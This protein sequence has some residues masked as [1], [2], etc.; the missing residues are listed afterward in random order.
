MP[1]LSLGTR[2]RIVSLRID[3]GWSLRRIAQHLN[4]SLGAVRG[5][6]RVY[7]HSQDVV[8]LPRSGR[9]SVTDQ[10]DNNFLIVQSQQQPFDSVGT[11]RRRLFQERHQNVSLSTVSRRLRAGGQFSFRP[12][13]C[14]TLTEQHRV[15]RLQWAH[16]HRAW[17]A[18]QQWQLV[19]FSDESRFCL[20]QVDGRLRVRRERNTRYSDQHATA[21][22]TPFG[23]GSVMVWGAISWNHRSA[24]VLV[25]G[26]L[27]GQRYL[28]EILSEVAIPFGLASV[29]AGF[30]FQDDNAR[31]HRAQIVT[32][33][34]EQHLD[35]VHMAWPACSPDLSPIEHA[36]DQLGRAVYAR[37]PQNL[38]ELRL[39]LMQEWEDL[40]QDR[41]RRLIRSMRRRCDS[42]IAAQGGATR[43]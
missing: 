9:P 5:T 8:D 3:S 35:Y 32:E 33:F 39:F 16:Q 4:V 40:P 41:I 1:R 24:L 28:D 7:E 12:L 2:W 21:A 22:V 34:H 13:R 27:T 29:G 26:S 36:W 19:V 18:L 14:P 11:L 42:V 10:H 6:L 20:N 15:I 30:I 31:P 38:D 43:Y 23:G 17:T 37:D 25:D